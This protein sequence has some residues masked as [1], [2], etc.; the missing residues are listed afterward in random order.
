MT[1]RTPDADPTQKLCAGVFQGERPVAPARRFALVA[2]PTH[3]RADT[4]SQGDPTQSKS[5][6]WGT[7]ADGEK[8]TIRGREY[9]CLGWVPVPNKVGVSVAAVLS[10]GC[11][12]CGAWFTATTSQRDINSGYP[13]KRCPAHRRK[14]AA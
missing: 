9:V 3:G 14:A 8:T 2:N 12:E 5:Q 1:R 11:A 6:I 4:G 13:P 10:S 7:L